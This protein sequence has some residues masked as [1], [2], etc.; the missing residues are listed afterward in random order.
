MKLLD[1]TDKNESLAFLQSC[2]DTYVITSLRGCIGYCWNEKTCLWTEFQ[3]AKGLLMKVSNHLE[4]LYKRVISYQRE[5]FDD[6][7]EWS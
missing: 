1:G 7:D 2:G 3:S 6:D 4:A 5:Q